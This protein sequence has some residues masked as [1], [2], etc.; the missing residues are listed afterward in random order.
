MSVKQTLL[1]MVQRILESRD[2][3]LI[4]SI[5]DTR[6]AMQVANIIKECYVHLLYVREIKTRNSLLTFDSM[7]DLSHPTYLRFKDDVAQI[8]TLK[9][10][11]TKENK[12]VDLQLLQPKDF[13]DRSL[14]LN[15]ADTN[16]I[17]VTDFSG[18]SFNVYNDR[19]PQFWTSFDD[20]HIVFDAFDSSVDNTIQNSKTVSYGIR[21]PEFKLEDTFVPDLAPQHFSYLLSK[22]KVMTAMELDKEYNQLEDDRARK[23]LLTANEH[24]RRLRGQLPVQWQNRMRTGRHSGLLLR[25]PV[26]M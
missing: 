3:Q 10:F 21:I 19:A 4:N 17:S 16:V 12:Y 7:S 14:C 1:E 5:Y 20:E 2:M 15:P 25:T 11:D 22:A 9:Y 8:D 18:I 26:T 23:E 13:L 24:S 6:E